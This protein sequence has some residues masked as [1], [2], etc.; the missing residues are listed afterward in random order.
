[1]EFPPSFVFSRMVCLA[2]YLAAQS[3]D[4]VGKFINLVWPPYIFVIGGFEQSAW[5]SFFIL[6][7]S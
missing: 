5:L 2:T 7:P 3:R 1:M 6:H 4:S